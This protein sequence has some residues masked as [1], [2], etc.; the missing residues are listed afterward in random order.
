MG[1]G[2]R[3]PDLFEGLQHPGQILGRNADT[4]INDPPRHG[5]RLIDAGRYTDPPL[6]R[7]KFD[8]IR[9]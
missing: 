6:R 7:G 1:V 3:A 8:G 9:Q 4:R 5:V 2:N